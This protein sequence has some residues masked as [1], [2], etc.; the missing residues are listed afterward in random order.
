MTAAHSNASPTPKSST[1]LNFVPVRAAAK[2]E[3][4]NEIPPFI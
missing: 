1:R 3:R 4:R 2:A